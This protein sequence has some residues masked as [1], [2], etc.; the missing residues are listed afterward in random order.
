M[1][2]LV[3]GK[4]CHLIH[5]HGCEQNAE[6]E[7][8]ESQLEELRNSTVEQRAEGRYIAEKERENLK[9]LEERKKML[10]KA[11]NS[12]EVQYVEMKNKVGGWVLS[13]FG[14]AG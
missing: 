6:I 3:A 4:F 7:N 13:A 5:H 8:L 11:A 12:C 14:T 2:N 9:P 1:T 10:Q